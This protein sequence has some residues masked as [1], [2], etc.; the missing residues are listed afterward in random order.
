MKIQSILCVG[1]LALSTS[2]FA[3]T[4]SYNVSF[5][6]PVKAGSITIDPGKY[7]LTVDGS[8]AV[9]DNTAN[10]KTLSVPVKVESM[11]RKFNDTSWQTRD[12]N[13]ARVLQSMDLGGSTTK[14]DFSR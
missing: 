14:L 12:Q 9:F 11:S 1:I 3:R 6:E 10:G 2:A 4:K 8:S 5:S 7:K 13:G